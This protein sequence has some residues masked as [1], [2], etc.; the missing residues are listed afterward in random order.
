MNWDLTPLF[1]NIEEAQN[2]IEE[3]QND[4]IFFQKEY[5]NRLYTL[6]SNEFLESL[7]H[8][9]RINEKIGRVMTYIFLRFATDSSEGGVLAKFESES[10]KIEEYLIFYDLEFA[11]LP[12][13]KQNNFIENSGIYK[14]YLESI[15][16]ESIHMLDENSEKIMMKKNLTSSSAWSR[17]FDEQFSKMKF[18]DGEKYVSEEEILSLLYSNN[19][20]TRKKAQINFT[21]GLKPHQ[22]LLAYIFN[23]IKKDLKIDCEIRNYSSP[24]S[25]RHISNKISQQSVDSLVNTVNENFDIV[26]KFYE[27]KKELLGYDKLYDY[28]RYAPLNLNEKK[29][30]FEEAKEIVLNSFRNFSEE[31]YEIALKA[32][33]E[34]WIDVYPK[35]GKRGG[36]FSHSATPEVHPY[37]LLNYTNQRRDIF[38]LAHEL[39]HAIHQYLA[40]DVG[41]LNQDTPLTTAETASVFSEMLLFEEMKKSL[42]KEELIPI[43]AGK[44]EDIFATLFRQIVFTNFERRVHK[45]EDELKENQY[46]L[47]W[48]EENERMFGESLILTE[49]YKLWWSYIPHFIHSPFYCY[50][51][52]YAQ[53]L[54]VSIFGLYKNGFANFTTEY[55]NFL[56]SGGSKSPKEQISKFN[57][58]IDKKE[59]WEI[60]VNEVRNMLN[61]F[62]NLLK[63]S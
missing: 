51:Y 47:I 19:R 10:T 41:F 9:E 11:K 59:F 46:N 54:V 45:N 50:S 49:N 39:G 63:E 38:T 21:N 24:E 33:D 8:Y 26:H 53:I 42:S 13:E 44:L 12:L 32:F 30:T 37:V 20:E 35:E 1:Q 56:A 15:Q 18:F 55:K 58:D 4:A 40:K 34:K 36:A 60:G 23:Q 6:N 61:E 29:V 16:K 7:K 5:K 2:L 28:D 31:F 52:S 25:P 57:Y 43:Y 62:E 17:L 48:Q 22:P 27:L 14:F 3:A